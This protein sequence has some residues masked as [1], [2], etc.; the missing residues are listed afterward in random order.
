MSTARTII[1]ALT[2]ALAAAAPAAVADT[3]F[4]R[5]DT[6]AVSGANRAVGNTWIVITDEFR[7]Y[8]YAGAATVSTTRTNPAL[9]VP[10]LQH[11]TLDFGT[12]GKIAAVT[13]P[14]ID[15]RA[16][17]GA[18]LLTMAAEGTFSNSSAW[19]RRDERRVPVSGALQLRFVANTCTGSVTYELVDADINW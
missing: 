5:L 19:L 8:R 16:Y 1:V 7:A 12:N 10:T 13:T 18:C 15:T 3:A 14:D 9:R 11:I 17:P 4:G 2:L 6:T